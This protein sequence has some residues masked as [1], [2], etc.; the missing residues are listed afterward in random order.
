MALPMMRTG[1]PLEK[2]PIA[3]SMPPPQAIS[4]LPEITA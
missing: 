2:P 1:A 3:D 4:M